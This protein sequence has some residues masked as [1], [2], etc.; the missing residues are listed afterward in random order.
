MVAL[1]AAFLGG[2]GTIG[3]ATIAGT[4]APGFSIGTITVHGDMTFAAP[5]VFLVEISPTAADRTNVTWASLAGGT[6]QVEAATGTYTPG[7]TYTILNADGGVNGT[8]AGLTSD[9]NSVFLLPRSATMQTT[10][11]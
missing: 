8:F 1:P 6:V 11:S 9:F 5:G 10:C 7:T 2:N 3:P 4:L